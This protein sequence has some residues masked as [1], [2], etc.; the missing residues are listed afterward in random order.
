MSRL[1]YF[2]SDNVLAEQPNPYM[3]RLSINQALEMGIEI[4]LELFEDNFN[5]DELDVILFCADQ[6]NFGYPNIFSIKKESYYGEFGTSK[7]FCTALEWDYSD[8]TVDVVLK[9][10]Q[11]HLRTASELELWSVW[12]ENNEIPTYMKKTI[13]KVSN[14]TI[15]RLKQFYTSE[16]DF[17]CLIVVR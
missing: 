15:D 12:L 8:D 13:C 11:S 14:L 10:I 2:A 16:L 4:D 17:E 6:V 5:K 3:K 1:Y 9:Y 7:Q